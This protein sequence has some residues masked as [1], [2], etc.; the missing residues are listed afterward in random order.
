MIE[1]FDQPFMVRALIAGVMLG[2]LLS[3]LGIFVTVRKMSFF[4]DGI[5]HA[6]LAGIAIAIL[7]GFST[8]PIAILWGVAVASGIYIFE[9]KTKLSSDT[10][11]GI[12]FT[13]SMAFGVI[14]MQFTQGYQP[15]LISFLF[16]NILTVR[17][18][19][20]AI[21][22]VCTTLIFAWLIPSFKSMLH[23]SLSE[24]SAKVS[25]IKSGLQLYLFYLALAVATVLGVKILGVVM[26]SALFVIP[27]AIA[28][29]FSKSFSSYSRWS[30]IIAELIILS[31]LIISYY[32]DIPS[33]AT[34]VLV[35][36]GSFFLASVLSQNKT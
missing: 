6:S 35:G 17:E 31:G 4:G 7:A 9:Q 16:G 33:G 22:A 14:L 2:L 3:S 18:I 11:I 24:E 21:M 23:L 12:F 15:E 8:L 34:I 25:G 28:R 20:I 32:A 19:D 30:I 10:L 27:P 26:V 13:A 36:A 5:A 29:L 1:I